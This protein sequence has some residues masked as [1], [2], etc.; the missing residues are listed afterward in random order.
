[1]A[2]SAPVLTIGS[3]DGVHLGH[4][5][6]VRT[7]RAIAGDG[8]VVALAFDPHPTTILAPH[9]VPA[10]LSVFDDRAALLVRSGADTVHRLE[11]TAD[12]LALTPEGFIDRL[13]EQYAPA[14]FVEG[15]DFRFGAGRAGSVRTLETLGRQ[16]GFRVD[17]VPPVEVDLNDQTLITA[18]STVAR[19]LIARGRVAD[20]GRV[21][22][23]PYE[24]SGPVRRGDQRG[25]TI[26]V[27]TANVHPE[28]E[29]PADGVYAGEAEL[30]DGR[31]L[32]A[33]I[34]VGPRHTFD[35][36][37]RTVE[38]HVVGWAGPVPEG[39][40]E[41]GWTIRLRFIQWLRGQIRFAGVDA[42]V[43]QMRRDLVRSAEVH[44]RR[45][46]G[47]YPPLPPAAGPRGTPHHGAPAS[48]TGVGAGPTPRTAGQEATA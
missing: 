4:A 34:H 19:W 39:G 23:R 22:G 42:L 12:L 25:R 37:E 43:E 38:A 2:N 41:Y 11:P 48:P 46:A 44:A 29:P 40:D 24:L 20:A 8:P 16:R 9:R 17:V 27:P 1:M 47:S 15:P 36:P 35:A 30:P 18:S 32:P 31:T 45:A 28:T 10:R 3:F 6:L 13:V 33:A 5:A 26:G 21:L 7:A 14:A